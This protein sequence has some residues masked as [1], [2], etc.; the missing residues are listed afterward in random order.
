MPPDVHVG[1][2]VEPERRQRRLNRLPLRIGEPG[3]QRHQHLEPVPH[4]RPSRT[5]SNADASAVGSSPAAPARRRYASK[6]SPVTRSYASRYREAVP[7]TTSSGSEGGGRLVVPSARV[8][9]VPHELLVEAGLRTSRLVPIDRPEPAGVGRAHL[10]D[11][12]QLTSGEAELELRVGHDHAAIGGRDPDA[13]VDAERELP[14]PLVE[15]PANQVGGIGR[16]QGQVVA[17]GRFRRGREDRLGELVGFGESGGQTHAA[18][19][20][21]GPVLRPAAAAQV[22]ARDA[23]E[24]DHVGA[25]HEQRS[26]RQARLIGERRAGT[27]H[28]RRSTRGCRRGRRCVRTSGA[29]GR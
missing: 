18:D 12:D 27:R 4:A 26:P 13:L 25:A 15:P 8:E 3:L 23:L 7:D 21:A 2:V 16:G 1:H 28:G 19:R 29:T 24:R 11:E 10:V 22:A 9:P 20:T 17:F 5:R 6:P 14:Q